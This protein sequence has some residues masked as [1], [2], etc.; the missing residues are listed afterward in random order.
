MATEFNPE[1]QFHSYWSTACQHTEHWECRGKCKY[2]PSLCGCICHYNDDPVGLNWRSR[3]EGH[4]FETH[5]GNRNRPIENEV[6]PVQNSSEREP[7]ALRALDLRIQERDDVLRI[8]QGDG[9]SWSLADDGKYEI[10]LTAEQ[11]AAYRHELEKRIAAAHAYGATPNT[12][13]EA[14][15]DELQRRAGMPLP[16]QKEHRQET[17]DPTWCTCGKPWRHE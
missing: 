16:D 15:L 13:L 8:I 9:L 7:M 14:A 5:Q 1:P 2:C 10:T 3:G 6:G 11:A 4:G 17:L 12:S